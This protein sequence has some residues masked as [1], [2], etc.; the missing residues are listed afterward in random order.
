MINV[1][2][3]IWYA[4]YNF[5]LCYYVT[6]ITVDVDSVGDFA[7]NSP[8]YQMPR[9]ERRIVQMVICRSQQPCEIKGLGV[10]VCS[11]ETYL[12][13]IFVIFEGQEVAPLKGAFFQADWIFFWPF[14]LIKSSISYY[15][16]F[17]RLNS[18]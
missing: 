13:V 8:W 4:I 18:V 2:K 11:M 17:R 7:Y 14:Q 12:T 6:A 10:F 9:T 3:L 15:M 1:A 5:T 16:L